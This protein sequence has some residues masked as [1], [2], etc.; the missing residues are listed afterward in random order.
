MAPYQSH[1]RACAELGLAPGGSPS[2][3]PEPGWQL[4]LGDPARPSALR[5]PWT[6][7]SRTTG[8]HAGAWPHSRSLLQLSNV[9]S[10]RPPSTSDPNPTVPRA[11]P[12]T[13]FDSVRSATYTEDSKS[14]V[15]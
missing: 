9:S 13:A 15:R 3:S 12:W 4:L 2:P 5:L 11:G 14:F 1:Q 7:S 6:R 8:P 10:R